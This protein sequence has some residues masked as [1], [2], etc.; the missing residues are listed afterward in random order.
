MVNHSVVSVR[1]WLFTPAARPDR[2]LSAAGKGVD[3]SIAD[4]EDSVVAAQKAV[5]RD[6]LRTLLDS[7]ANP[8]LPRLAV[9][10]NSTS[11]RFG[12]D[13]LVALLD[14]SRAPDFILLPKI[15]SP[16]QVVQIATLFDQA[17]KACALVP[18]IES[19]RGLAAVESIANAGP[20]VAALMF[21]AA[22][23][24]SD[25]RAH[26]DARRCKSRVAAWLRRLHRR[27]SRLSM[28]HALPFTT[29]NFCKPIWPLRS[30]TAFTARRPFIP[31]ISHPSTARSRRRPIA[32]RGLSACSRQTNKAR[33]LWM[34]A[35]STRPLP[36][37]RA[38][39]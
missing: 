10:I 17:G 32:L 4:L 30:P 25:V 20:R 38:V 37:K 24:A 12:L 21:G 39:C 18:M 19:A 16:E 33:A 2:L 9:R 5:A 35:W 29:L 7:A 34:G 23:Y 31:R 36:G 6:K 8:L 14:A 22:E 1:S 13:D 3:L 28:R 15:E 26:P 27:E 11:T